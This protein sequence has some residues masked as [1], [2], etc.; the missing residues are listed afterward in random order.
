MLL[1]EPISSSI[2]GAALAVAS[3]PP[4][5]CKQVRLVSG[6]SA[7]AHGV[8]EEL[9]SRPWHTEAPFTA[10]PPI[11]ACVSGTGCVSGPHDTH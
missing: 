7:A 5:S 3:C 9:R 10:G 4:R 6:A 8:A 2:E 1:P 11:A